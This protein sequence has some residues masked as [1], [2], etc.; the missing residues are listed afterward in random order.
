MIRRRAADGILLIRQTDHAAL[1]A[2]LAAAVGNDRFPAPLPRGPVLKA[3][4]LHDAGWPLHDDSPTLNSRGEPTDVFEMPAADALAIW[5]ASTQRAAE[6]D[7]YIGLLVSLHGLSL[8][9]L[10]QPDKARR[11]HDIFT[12][13]KFQHAQIEHQEEFRRRLG[14][15]VD[16][17]LHNGLADA[18]A[19]PQE[20]LLRR[21]FSLLQFT[22]LLSL[23]LCMDECKFPDA[24]LLAD[25]EQPP[26]RLAISRTAENIFSID[27]W[28]FEPRALQLSVPARKIP[29]RPY[30]DNEDLR[31]ADAAAETVTLPIHL[32]AIK[33]SAGP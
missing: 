3:V 31:R 27:P 16:S 33:P 20:D 18:G 12:L 5:A 28:P 8:S 21:N 30:S 9:S 22:D 10:I 13:I 25:A 17:P 19:S 15:N 2:G 32:A 26:I 4:D 6:I 7:P 29:N 1:A 23:D 11:Q 14:M 24:D